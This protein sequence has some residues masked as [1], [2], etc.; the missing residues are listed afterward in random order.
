MSPNKRHLCLR[1]IHLEGEGPG[2]RG[3]FAS[4]IH[5]QLDD[6]GPI[7]PWAILWAQ[8]TPGEDLCRPR[9]FARYAWPI[10]SDGSIVLFRNSLDRPLGYRQDWWLPFDCTD[11]AHRFNPK[12]R[13]HAFEPF[14]A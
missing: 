13:F 14:R 9:K 6:R 2:V 12:R 7:S 5:L 8:R 4:V 11:A 3:R 1:S 10:Y